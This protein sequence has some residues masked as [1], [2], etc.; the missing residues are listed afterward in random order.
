ML[1]ASNGGAPDHPFW[2]LNLLD[3][4]DVTVQVGA[5]TFAARAEVAQADERPR[6]WELM[7]SV[8]ARYAAY[9]AQTDRVIPV[10]VVTRTPEPLVTGT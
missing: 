9:Q 10:V 4:A 2:Y 6:L 7:V 8:F 3:C 5:E 1:V